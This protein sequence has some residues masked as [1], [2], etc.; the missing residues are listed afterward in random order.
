MSDGKNLPDWL[1]ERHL[2]G[3]LTPEQ[4]R[5]VQECLGEPE[6]ERRL[7]ELRS[8][9]QQVLAQLPAT[10]VAAEVAR[11]AGATAARRH[12]AVGRA[13]LAAL[14]AAAA[15][16]VLLLLLRP[17]SL[18]RSPAGDRQAGAVVEGVRAKGAPR[19]AVFR[20]TGTGSESLAPGA[21]VRA[22]DLLQL[23][24][25]PAGFGHA[26]V[27]SV[28]G[29]GA[30]TLHHPRNAGQST[31]LPPGTALTLPESYELDDAPGFERFFLV[32]SRE[33][34]AV[35]VV[36]RAA[37]TLAAGAPGASAP[38]ALPAGWQQSSFLLRKGVVR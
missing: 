35:D 20:R 17:A 12:R 28:D 18:Q 26:V 14:A 16:A 24:I 27:V 9:D 4:A 2:L 32:V 29:G 19:L 3:E 23:S 33:P 31:A 22:G 10:A 11:R 5:R 37:R 34:I 1:L 36:L 30:V 6:L 25:T 38:L 7:A 8:D 15:A 13:P 21:Q